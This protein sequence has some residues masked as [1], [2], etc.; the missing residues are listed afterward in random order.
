M[1][2]HPPSYGITC[3]PWRGS[4]SARMISGRNRLHTYEQFEYVKSL[5]RRLLT[6]APPMNGLRSSTC[7]LSPAR[8]R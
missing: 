8:A 3:R 6:A 1:K 7:T 5:Y 4:S 2:V